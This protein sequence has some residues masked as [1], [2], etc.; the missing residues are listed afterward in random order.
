MTVSNLTKMVESSPDRL[1]NAVEKG[2]LALQT[3]INKGLLWKGL[4]NE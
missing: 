2:D 4:K 1:E 3:G